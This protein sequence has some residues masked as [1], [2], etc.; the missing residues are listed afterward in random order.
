MI[1][2]LQDKLFD[3]TSEQID[4]SSKDVAAAEGVSC[5]KSLAHTDNPTTIIPKM[6]AEFANDV[7]ESTGKTLKCAAQGEQDEKSSELDV[8]EPPLKA[9]YDDSDES[10]IVEHDVSGGII[11]IP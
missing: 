7:Q 9:D 2:L 10:E 11:F 3:S 5:Q 8:R 4:G 6:E 1:C